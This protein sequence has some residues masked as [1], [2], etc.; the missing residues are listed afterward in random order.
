MDTTAF[1]QMIE[2]LREA[3]SLETIAFWGIG[4]PLMH[5]DIIEMVSRAKDLGVRTEMISNGLLL[6]RR[7]AE[8]LTEAGLDMLVIS[9]DGVSADTYG[10]IRSGGNLNT[11]LHNVHYLNTLQSDNGR[12]HPEIGIEFVLMKRNL[13]ELSRLRDLAFVMGAS[14]IFI[15][16][17]L[18]YSEEFKDEILYWW[19]ASNI[20]YPVP[21]RSRQ[22]PEVVL[23][24]MDERPEHIDAVKGLLRNNGIVNPVPRDGK[25]ATACCPF[26]QEGSMSIAWDGTV[27]PCI[28]LMH[29][30][31]CYVLR[32]EKQI[33]R[34]PLGNISKESV[35]NIWNTDEFKQFR[36]RVMRPQPMGQA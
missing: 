27:S 1:K 29:S 35:L 33:R 4:E 17:L 7:M 2:T 20:C 15:S 26:V 9:V 36:N 25:G 16:N 24:L 12:N 30:Y 23:P 8:G 14:V 21:R 11:V 34:Y 10:D 22:Y 31:T 13:H 28:A 18:P 3:S 6:D 19:S 5:P 32:R